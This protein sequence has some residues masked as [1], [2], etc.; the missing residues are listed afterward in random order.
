MKTWLLALF[1]VALLA[2]CRSASPLLSPSSLQQPVVP[3][4]TLIGV[5]AATAKGSGG[6]GA[7]SAA[8]E[9]VA[10]SGPCVPEDGSA[11]P[12]FGESPDCP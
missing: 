4:S 2:G 3:A 6:F 1:A 10:A 8:K 12:I 11:A 5:D 9:E 7:S